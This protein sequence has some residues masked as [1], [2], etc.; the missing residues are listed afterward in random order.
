MKKASKPRTRKRPS[1]ANGEA[2][3]AEAH[4]AEIAALFREQQSDGLDVAALSGASAKHERKRQALRHRPGRER[5]GKRDARGMLQVPAAQVTATHP[6]TLVML[7]ELTWLLGEAAEAT[8]G[9]SMPTA[10]ALLIEQAWC[11]A[12]GG[13]VELDWAPRLASAIVGIVNG[14]PPRQRAE[15]RSRRGALL[16][17]EPAALIRAAH[18]HRPL[19]LEPPGYVTRAVVQ[20]GTRHVT[21]SAR[22]GGTRHSGSTLAVL[23]AHPKSLAAELERDDRAAARS[24]R[25]WVAEHEPAAEAAGALRIIPR[26]SPPT[27]AWI[28]GPRPDRLDRL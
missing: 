24:L 22:G 10:L 1:K 4:A 17:L 28:A 2:A 26:T 8:R 19:L 21:P 20:W 3:H 11:G 7:A 16:Q 6:R 25:A 5:L 15:P 13:R 23:L 9:D 18:P 14:T 27:G 12:F